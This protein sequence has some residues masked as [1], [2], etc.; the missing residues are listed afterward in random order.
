MNITNTE[1]L[2]VPRKIQIETTN[3]CNSKCNFCPHHVM[4]RKAEFMSDKLL[5]RLINEITDIPEVKVLEISGFGEPLLDRHRVFESIK[6]VKE[7][8]PDIFTLFYTNGALLTPETA[9]VP[10]DKITISF[11]GGTK[12]AYETT[13]GTLK[14]EDVLR[15]VKLFLDERQKHPEILKRMKVYTLMIATKYNASTAP[16]FQELWKGYANVTTGLCQSRDWLGQYERPHLLLPYDKI[17]YTHGVCHRLKYL[18]EIWSNGDLALCCYDYDNKHPFGSVV[19]SSLIEV[20]ASP[21][22]MKIVEDALK[23]KYTIPLCQHCNLKIDEDP[24][25]WPVPVG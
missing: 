8:R 9:H 7:K 18:A 15:S 21:K 3:H 13:M 23:C 20:W 22:R 12:E 6:K 17:P 14:F 16:Q 11:N 19:D 4:K 25:N 24:A 10:I 5:T 1:E 2:K